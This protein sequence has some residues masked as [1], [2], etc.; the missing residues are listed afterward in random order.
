MGRGDPAE[1][2]ELGQRQ[3]DGRIPYIAAMGTRLEYEPALDGL[4]AIAVVLVMA[5]HARAPFFHA[6][7]VGVDVFFVLSGFLISTIL[8]HQI[9]ATG[10]IGFLEF[11][12]RRF[13]RLTPALFAVL[14][15]YIA[16]APFAWPNWDHDRDALLAALYISDYSKA[17]WDLPNYISHTWSLSVEEHFYILWPPVL[18]LLHRRYAGRRLLVVLA[19]LFLIATAWRWAWINRGTGWIEVYSRFDTRLTG[20]MLGSLLAAALS[21]SG[22]RVFLCRWK[23]HVY[24]LPILAIFM[25]NRGWF[26]DWMLRYG[27]TFVELG[28][29][30]TILAVMFREAWLTNLL[31]S[32]WMVQVGRLSYAIYLWHYPIMRLLRD[33]YSWPVTMLLGSILS[34]ALAWASART[35]ERWGYMARDWIL[36]QRRPRP[37]PSA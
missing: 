10:T 16:I 28:T 14:L 31:S 8:L 6:G 13:F 1:E 33:N 9:A 4:R 19:S 20:M 23:N 12:T 21:D 3:G 37:A 7:Y 27:L 18:L 35:I 25:A 34:F 32:P 36:R 30:A 5:F 15:V 29:A 2:A 17:F 24:L 22:C 11:D 26:S